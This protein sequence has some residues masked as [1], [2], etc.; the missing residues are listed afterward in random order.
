MTSYSAIISGVSHWQ[1]KRIWHIVQ[2]MNHSHFLV[3]FHRLPLTIGI[4]ACTLAMV[5]LDYWVPSLH[6]RHVNI[7]L[8]L[9]RHDGRNVEVHYC[10]LLDVPDS[11][12]GLVM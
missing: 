2:A 5:T 4:Q 11:D 1:E 8:D 7:S 10:Y 9:Q 12:G 3:I 6:A